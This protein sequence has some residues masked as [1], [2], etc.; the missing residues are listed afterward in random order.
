MQGLAKFKA[1]FPSLRSRVPFDGCLVLENEDEAVSIFVDGRKFTVCL[2]KN[3]MVFEG[4]FKECR[5]FI[6]ERL[7]VNDE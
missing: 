5:E 3:D 4:G 1:A 6:K 2:K 7:G